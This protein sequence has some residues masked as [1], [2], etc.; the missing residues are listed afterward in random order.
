MKRIPLIISVLAAVL[1]LVSGLGA[2]AELW[3]FRTGFTLLRWAALAG[4]LAVVVAL[5]FLVVPKLRQSNVPLLV[6]AVLIGL[7]TAYLPWS[8]Q[9]RARSV[10]PIHDI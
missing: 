8:W 9:R 6:L 10:P 4:L 7:F 5:V 3:T 1:L 2:R